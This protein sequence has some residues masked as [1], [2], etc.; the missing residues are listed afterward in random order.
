MANKEQHCREPWLGTCCTPN[1][2][3]TPPMTTY[4]H[5][6]LPTPHCSWNPIIHGLYLL[7]TTTH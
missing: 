3:Q 7:W 5:G 1:H 4:N 2:P 6:P